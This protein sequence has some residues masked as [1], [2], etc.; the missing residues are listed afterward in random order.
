VLI[1]W[2][3]V[4]AQVVNFLLLVALLKHF[5]YGPILRAMDRR[6]QNIA[7]RFAEAEEAVKEAE[8]RENEYQQLRRDLDEARDERLREVEEEAGKRR[9]ELEKSA[10]QEVA[11]LRDAWLNAMRR[12]RDDFFRELQK[13]VGAT[14]L[15]IARK[16]LVDLTDESLERRLVKHFAA[17]FAKLEIKDQEQVRAAAADNELT[18]RGSFEWPEDLRHEF[19]DR[20][21]EIFDQD[22]D[23]SFTTDPE[24]PLGVELTVGGIKLPW[25]IDSY[26]AEMRN[27]VAELYD[28]GIEEVE[29]EKARD[30]L[31]DKPLSNKEEA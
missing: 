8:A 12:E 9:K 6:E 1:D 26:F 29:A 18:V 10:R 13:R 24:M 2:F 16:S 7:D 31:A 11:D 25:G 3:T 15:M 27:A 21:R 28:S 22:V 4:A 14:V 19:N 20:L 17:Q 30:L 23:I 5:L